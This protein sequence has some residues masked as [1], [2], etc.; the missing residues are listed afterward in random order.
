M[1][2][3][4]KPEERKKPAEDRQV[5]VLMT[6]RTAGKKKPYVFGVSVKASP[7]Y[8]EIGHAIFQRMKQGHFNTKREVVAYVQTLL[9]AGEDV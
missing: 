8:R 9:P 7:N 6:S 4:S 3:K 2:R 1:I 5:Y